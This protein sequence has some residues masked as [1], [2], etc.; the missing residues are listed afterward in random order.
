MSVLQQL[1]APEVNVNK[2]IGSVNRDQVLVAQILKLIN[3]GFYGMSNEVTKVEHAINL[4]GIQKIKEILYSLSVMDTLSSADERLWLHSFSTFFLMDN[5][6]MKRHDL[7]V[8]H[9]MPLTMLMHDIGQV[10]MSMLNPASHRMAKNHS[11]N[12]GLPLSHSEEK[13]LDVNHGEVGGW[14]MEC[15]QMEPQ[16]VIPIAH[17]HAPDIPDS[18]VNET[19]LLQIVDW[20][21]LQVR[22]MPAI[23]PA[24]DLL[25]KAG[26]KD[27]EIE[28]W[29]G[30]HSAIIHS[31]DDSNPI[32]L[33]KSPTQKPKGF[34]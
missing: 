8:S 15:W 14:I 6:L 5:I 33:M 10:V 17:H 21:D 18:H 7:G 19:A 12:N 4:L 23:F 24:R 27:F 2:L 16:V 28:L 3:S 25:A 29:M 31:L 34:K 13:I 9:D 22:G 32:K 20:I 1:R 11:D 30:K 26:M